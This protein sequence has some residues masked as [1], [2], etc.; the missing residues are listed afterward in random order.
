MEELKNFNIHS[1]M[2]V[3]NKSDEDFEQWLKEKKLLWTTRVCECGSKMVLTKDKNWRCYK[4]S[5][6]NNTQPRKGLYD[7]TFF[8]RSH[9][10]P[11]QIFEFTYYWCR[12]THT[13]DEFQHDMKLSTRTIVDWKQYCRDIAISYFKN[14]PEK[15]GFFNLSNKLN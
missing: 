10:S 8:S 9:L 13:Q 7:G 6:H 4:K 11:K 5:R 14:H 12:N 3:L 2:R 1:L 15:I